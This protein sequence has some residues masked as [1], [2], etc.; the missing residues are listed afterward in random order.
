MEYCLRCTEPLRG[1]AVCPRCGFSGNVP[2]IP[3]HLRPGTVLNDRYLVG[4]HIGQGGF[5]ITYVGRD[6][7]LDMRIAIKEYYP[8]GYANR[9]N[10]VSSGITIVDEA[11]RKF[12]EDGIRRF[13]AEAKVLARFVGEP[14]VV[15]VHDFFEANQTAYII[16]EYL[17]GRDL[18]EVLRERLFTAEEIFRL[19]DP[20]MVT[21]EKIHETGIIHRDIS[22]DNLMML[23]DGRMKLMDFGSARLVDYSDQRSLSVV[24]KA[25]FAPEEQYRSKGKQGPWTDIYALCCTIYKCITGI[26]P[27]DALERVFEDNVTWP[28]EMKVPITPVQEAVLK[29]GMAVRYTERFQSIAEMRQALAGAGCGPTVF[30][31]ERHVEIHEVTPTILIEP[32]KQPD[33]PKAPMPDNRPSEGNPPPVRPAQ[34]PPV[35]KPGQGKRQKSPSLGVLQNVGGLFTGEGLRKVILPFLGLPLFFCIASAVSEGFFSMLGLSVQYMFNR[36][37]YTYGYGGLAIRP[38]H[39]I[40]MLLFTIVVILAGGLLFQK[41]D[42]RVIAASAI[43]VSLACFIPMLI[44]R[45]NLFGVQYGRIMW[46]NNLVRVCYAYYFPMLTYWCIML[47]SLLESVIHFAPIIFDALM[48]MMLLV[49]IPFGTRDTAKETWISRLKARRKR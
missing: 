2:D 5:G 48:C 45:L 26:T 24:L 10:R 4:C 21:L 3:H 15:I 42:R 9:N 27:D 8:S 16:M 22:P 32:P 25:G 13:L 28:S 31:P 44:M 18:R 43:T 19:M 47:V 17:D 41:A 12:F 14:G 38:V 30:L 1:Q 20:V 35:W 40:I 36:Y 23:K 33:P 11:N 37:I 46:I 34:T 29:K 39:V 7:K 6:L 49:L